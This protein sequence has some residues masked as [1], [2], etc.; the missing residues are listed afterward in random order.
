MKSKN[1]KKHEKNVNNFFSTELAQQNGKE[2]GSVK[3]ITD[4][5]QLFLKPPNKIG[6]SSNGVSFF[7]KFIYKY[8]WIYMFI[9][10]IYIYKYI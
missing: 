10:H 7:F 9:I 2:N 1:S 5:P 3:V 4:Q 8:I 6:M